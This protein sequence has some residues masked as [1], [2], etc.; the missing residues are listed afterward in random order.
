MTANTSEFADVSK[1][2]VNLSKIPPLLDVA[3]VNTHVAPLSRSLLYEL[4]SRGDIETASVGL[5]RGKRM[6][7]TSSLV[8]WLQK[9]VAQTKRPNLA[10]RQ[11]RRVKRRVVEGGA[12]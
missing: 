11:S 8:S 1:L 10:P 6:F 12:R 4:A 2:N 7:L 5:G 3:G 9:C